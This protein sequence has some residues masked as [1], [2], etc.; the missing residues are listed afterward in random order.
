MS[1][2]VVEWWQSGFGDLDR[3]AELDGER[4][5]GLRLI[6]PEQRDGSF[7]E[8]AEDDGSSLQGG[9]VDDEQPAFLE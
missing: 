6:D 3:L 1:L 5:E 7:L 2:V 4:H 8:S 9:V